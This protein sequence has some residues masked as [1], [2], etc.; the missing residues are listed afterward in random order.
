MKKIVLL[1]AISLF[2]MACATTE[3]GQK[4]NTSLAS[5]I[6]IGKTTEVE[7]LTTLGQPPRTQTRAN[8]E[9]TFFYAYTEA[10]ANLLGVNAKTERFTILFGKDGIV[11]ETDKTGIN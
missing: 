4:F 11:K 8:G 1:I 5:Q 3:V 2:L 6:E 9:K 10:K 7:V